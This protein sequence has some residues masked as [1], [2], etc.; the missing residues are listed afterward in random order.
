[1]NRTVVD[2]I[3]TSEPLELD[4]SELLLAVSE[5]PTK[6]DEVNTEPMWQA[7]MQE[8]LAAIVDNETWSLVD[9]PAGHR[10]IS[11]KWV[12]KHKK[13]A[14]GVVIHHKAQLMAKG[15]VQHAG[16]DFDEVFSLMVRLDSVCT[17]VDVAAHEG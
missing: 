1:M 15:Y 2:C 14:S 7:A 12:F 10:P 5:E 13:D 11:L 3:N 17:L 8:E 9:L 16:V 4:P 6:I